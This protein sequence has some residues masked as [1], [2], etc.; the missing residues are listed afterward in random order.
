MGR[1]NHVKLLIGILS[2]ASTIIFVAF[3][4]LTSHVYVYLYSLLVLIV[5][6]F[7]REK[8]E[9]IPI[10]DF[11][12]ASPVFGVF[13]AL[14]LAGYITAAWF[15][16]RRN[17]Y[18]MIGVVSPPLAFL[19]ERSTFYRRDY[20][21]A[22]LSAASFIILSGV[23]GMY[24]FA[25]YVPT[26]YFSPTDTTVLLIASMLVFM[27]LFMYD[28]Y[29]NARR[30]GFVNYI[31]LIGFAASLLVGL[32][33]PALA[34]SSLPGAYL[35]IRD[36]PKLRY[37]DERDYG[38][39]DPL[40]LKE[41]GDRLVE[42]D[43]LKN[44]IAE[45]VDIASRGVIKG[46][47]LSGPPGT[48]KTA[49][50]HYM[51]YLLWVKGFAVYVVNTKDIMSHLW[52]ETEKMIDY[53][54]D[55]AVNH[56]PIALIFDEVERFLW[57]RD[58]SV[59][60]EYMPKVVATFLS[61]WDDLASRGAKVLVI[62]TTNMLDKIDP[63]ALRGSRFSMVIDVSMPDKDAKL[64]ILSALERK[65]NV[66]LPVQVKERAASV[67]NQGDDLDVFMRCVAELGVSKCEV[68][69]LNNASRAVDSA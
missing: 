59:A 61:R 25:P 63:A 9:Y 19:V 55:Y 52:G 48:G 13:G 28:R 4:A 31:H 11:L 5:V 18:P 60:D 56:Q 53:I 50:A 21:Y 64:S 40:K 45:V 27:W 34:L 38:N 17:L 2:T 15:F 24:G 6:P 7:M 43:D 39:V 54:F 22:G 1:S 3:I 51:G 69:L 47:L 33:V 36:V 66:S 49:L 68:L 35:L 16:N 23:G 42:Y 46:V 30:H 29:M 58:V 67:L 8:P 44:T 14:M 41:E 20:V 57:R 37:E 32:L 10:I 12:A 26:V 62:G 65:Y